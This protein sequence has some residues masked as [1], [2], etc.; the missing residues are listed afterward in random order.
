MKLI[1][2]SALGIGTEPE[3]VLSK[4]GDVLTI[5][6]EAFDFSAVP[7]GEPALNEEHTV[8]CPFISG[9]VKRLGG[10]VVLNVIRFFRS[11]ENMPGPV[12]LSDVPDGPVALPS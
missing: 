7:E 6:G 8:S 5:N 12:I 3:L 1:V 9:S 4:S 2:H 10:H 11:P